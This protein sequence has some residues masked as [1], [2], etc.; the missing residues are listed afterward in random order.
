MASQAPLGDAVGGEGHHVLDGRDHV[1]PLSPARRPMRGM[2]HPLHASSRKA[3]FPVSVK[4][5]P[6][7]RRGGINWPSA[8]SVPLA[9]SR[10]MTSRRAV[11]KR[12]LV[13]G[14]FPFRRDR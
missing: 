8:A 5:Y 14:F 11:C 2:R 3:A 13:P 9:L 12:Q 6:E 10:S 4:R 7:R 1:R